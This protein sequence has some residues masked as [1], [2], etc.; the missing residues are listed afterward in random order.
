MAH[1]L[2]DLPLRV[3]LDGAARHELDGMYAEVKE[4]LLRISFIQPDNPDY[5]MNRI[6]HFFTR[7]QLR[8]KEVSI[9]RGICRQ[10]RWYADKRYQ[11]GRDS[12]EG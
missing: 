1:T 9:I 6:R 4:I 8:A 3:D 10:I 12:K 5:W 11:D 2:V 7:M